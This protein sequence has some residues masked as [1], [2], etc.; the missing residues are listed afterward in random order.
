MGIKQ[1]LAEKL[2]GIMVG[3]EYPTEIC[4][5][6]LTALAVNAVACIAAREGDREVRSQVFAVGLDKLQS[7]MYEYAE[8]T[9]EAIDCDI[10]IS[11]AMFPNGFDLSSL[12]E[13][14]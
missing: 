10:R 1:T 5:E 3:G 14:A 2:Q 12:K 11:V 13:R 6:V 4:M 7:N 8:Q 9:A